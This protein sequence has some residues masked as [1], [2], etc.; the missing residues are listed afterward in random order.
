[1]GSHSCHINHSLLREAVMVSLLLLLLGEDPGEEPPW[2]RLPAGGSFIGEGP[3]HFS[4]R[5]PVVLSSASA[6]RAAPSPPVSLEAVVHSKLIVAWVLTSWSGCWYRTKGYGQVLQSSVKNTQS[7]YWCSFK[8]F[9]FVVSLYLEKLLDQ[10]G[11]SVSINLLD[12]VVVTVANEN[13]W[14]LTFKN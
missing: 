7:F 12:L 3:W 13:L 10:L 14:M 8:R 6:G 11:R 2:A 5:H 4:R 1:M 9:G